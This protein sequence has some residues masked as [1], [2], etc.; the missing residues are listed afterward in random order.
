M[1]TGKFLYANEL[2]KAFQ[3]MFD[4]QM[5]KEMVVYMEACES[6]SMFEKILKKDLNIYAVSAANGK[7]SSW[8][9]YC[10]PDDKI[11]GKHVG[12][13][14]GDL[15]SVNWMEDT[16]QATDLDKLGIETLRTQY[17][18]I[19]GETNKSHVLQWGDLSF[20]EEPIGEFMAGEYTSK[21]TDMWT[22]FKSAGKT[23]MSDGFGYTTKMITQKNDFAVD[24]RDIDLHYLYSKVL[25]DPST[26]N[27]EALLAELQ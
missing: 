25:T 15:F 24:V 10:H 13:C 7:E 9:T 17:N 1:P 23:W 26:E 2:E 5:Y 12:S 27:Q 6:G 21:K 4:N 8:G 3:F 14:L 11:N 16:D 22:A 18:V 20:I 19:K